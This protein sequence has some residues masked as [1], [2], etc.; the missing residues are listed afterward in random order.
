MVELIDT[1]ERLQAEYLRNDL[2][3]HE[4]VE[5]LGQETAPPADE[6]KA[7]AAELL[8][9]VTANALLWPNLVVYQREIMAECDVGGQPAECV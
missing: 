9:V 6:R 8:N 3:K 1:L 2:R 4:I 5:L 7:P